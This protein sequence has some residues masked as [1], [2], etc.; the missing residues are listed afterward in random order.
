[1]GR[2]CGVQSLNFGKPHSLHLLPM[3]FSRHE[4][5]SVLPCP[6]PRYLPDPGIGPTTSLMT[7][8]LEAGSLPLA[9]PGKPT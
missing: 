2:A 6:P 5:W 7:P 3:G 9:P 1:M 4:Y 8:V